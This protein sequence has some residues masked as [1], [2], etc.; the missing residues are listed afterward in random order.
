MPGQPPPP[1]YRIYER[2]RRL[3]V[4]DQWAGK[5]GP[6]RS[7]ET[8]AGSTL[9]TPTAV[10]K[11]DRISFDGRTSFTT[12]PL[13]DAK[14]PRTIILD[15]GRA[16]MI[17]AMKIALVVGAI[18]VVALIYVAP[19]LLVALVVLFQRKTRDQCRSAATTW[20]DGIANATS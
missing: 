5:S 12:H 13:F 4:I 6:I 19:F 2:N 3:V 15:L 7:S 8:F 16:S 9:T 10:G 17:R 1:R 14:G 20:L 18:G 11:L